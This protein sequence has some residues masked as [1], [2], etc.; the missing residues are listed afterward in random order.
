M[1]SAARSQSCQYGDAYS[2]AGDAA[3]V[4]KIAFRPVSTGWSGE[5]SHAV[6]YAMVHL[7]STSHR[8]GE[9]SAL[10]PRTRLPGACHRAARRLGR[11]QRGRAAAHRLL[12]RLGRARI[13]RRRSRGRATIATVSPCLP[14]RPR[15]GSAASGCLTKKSAT[16]TT[17]LPTARCGR[18]AIAPTCSRFFARRI[19][20]PIG[21]STPDSRTRSVRKR[22]ARAA[23]VLVQDYH[24]ALAPLMIRQEQPSA[25]VATFW[26]IPWPHWQTFAACP[27]KRELL[28]GLLGSS[29]I[30]FQTSADCFNFVE[31]VDR[32]LGARDRLH[33]RRH[34]LPGPPH[35]RA[36]LPHVDRVARA[37]GEC[38]SG[39]GL[40]RG[41]AA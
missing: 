26:H 25:A 1:G 16:T 33:R 32:I 20:T 36:R 18:C 27:W 29:V 3:P 12:R 24:F 37:V 19:S 10:Q 35:R 14:R 11:R 2:R 22:E 40:P 8:P 30:G 9:S 39:V 23:I 21:R 31:T 15:I 17:A 5:R 4:S 41:G 13:R 6:P 7:Q 28:E 38:R 34:Y